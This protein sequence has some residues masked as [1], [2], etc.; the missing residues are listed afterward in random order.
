[1]PGIFRRTAR[2]LLLPTLTCVA[3]GVIPARGPE[4]Q[5][6]GPPSDPKS[7][8]NGLVIAWAQSYYFRSEL[9]VGWVSATSVQ[10]IQSQFGGLLWAIQGITPEQL[11]RDRALEAVPPL[12]TTPP[13]E[14]VVVVVSSGLPLRW[15]FATA[16]RDRTGTAWAAWSVEHGLNLGYQ[17]PV[18][19]DPPLVIPFGVSVPLLLANLGIWFAVFEVGRAIVVGMRAQLHSRRNSHRRCTR[20]GYPMGRV[21]GCP[22]CGLGRGGSERAA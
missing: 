6:A 20:C 14:R 13:D 18:P 9:L 21:P 19:D 16:H 4:W 7:V 3:L 22:E 15:S 5:P 11:A 8:G 12:G 1:M 2:R 10:R 17:Q